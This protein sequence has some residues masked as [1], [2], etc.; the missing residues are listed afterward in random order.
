MKNFWKNPREHDPDFES[1]KLQKHLQLLYNH[2]YLN[3]LLSDDNDYLSKDDMHFGC[4]SLANILKINELSIDEINE[5]IAELPTLYFEI[6]N[7]N[8][9]FNS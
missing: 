9:L 1:V 3:G 6:D 5:L 7:N 4:D 2:K 8:N